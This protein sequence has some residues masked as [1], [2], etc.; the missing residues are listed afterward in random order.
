MI[1]ITGIGVEHLQDGLFTDALYTGN[2]LSV[3]PHAYYSSPA[4]ASASAMGMFKRGTK[5]VYGA[6]AQDFVNKRG[7]AGFTPLSMVGGRTDSQSM[8][9]GFR[10]TEAKAAASSGRSAFGLC[11]SQPNAYSGP[12]TILLNYTGTYLAP[13]YYEFEMM[14][15]T[16]DGNAPMCYVYLDGVQI[17]STPNSGPGNLWLPGNMHGRWFTFGDNRANMFTSNASGQGAVGDSLIEFEDMYVAVSNVKGV[18]ARQ[19]PILLRRLDVG[20]VG[21]SSW[22]STDGTKTPVEVL[23]LPQHHGPVLEPVVTSDVGNTAARVKFDL[24]QVYDNDKILAVTGAASVRRAVGVSSTVA[25]KWSANGQDSAS[26]TTTPSNGAW[27]LQ[28]DILLPTLMAL[29]DGTALTKASLANLEL[30]LTP[31]S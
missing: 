15:Y 24:N 23:N 7:L 12:E 29:P 18:S 21:N 26:T 22:T 13:G 28:K 4:E 25:T 14:A 30:V 20:D 16:G 2:G 8:C 1:T 19:G 27:T 10:V 5:V 11:S 6:L 3:S 17:R 9:I 31:N